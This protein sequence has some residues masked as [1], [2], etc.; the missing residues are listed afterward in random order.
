MTKVLISIFA[1]SQPGSAVTPGALQ[2]DKKQPQL[3][4]GDAYPVTPRDSEGFTRSDGISQTL[5]HDIMSVIIFSSLFLA[6]VQFTQPFI[7]NTCLFT[8]F[9]DTVRRQERWGGDPPHPPTPGGL[10]VAGAWVLGSFSPAEPGWSRPSLAVARVPAE[11][12]LPR[13]RRACGSDDEHSLPFSR[14]MSN[15]DG[16]SSPPKHRHKPRVGYVRCARRRGLSSAACGRRMITRTSEATGFC[17]MTG[18]NRHPKRN[19]EGA[20][21][22]Q[23][24][25]DASV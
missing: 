3:W 1:S 10:M 16:V 19:S 13:G 23:C 25:A 17:E 20:L 18:K 24:A 2:S 22:L 15:V 6:L 8:T 5:P 11:A 21:L 9:L 4:T 14:E 12:S 7:F